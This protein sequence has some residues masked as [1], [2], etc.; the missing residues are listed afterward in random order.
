MHPFGGDGELGVSIRISG[1]GLAVALALA[2]TCAPAAAQYQYGDPFLPGY[3]YAPEDYGPRY[4]APRYY[5]PRYQAPSYQASRYHAPRN[6]AHKD[7]DAD[8]ASTAP[9]GD[10]AKGPLQ[11]YVSIDQQKLYLYSDGVHI[12]DTSVATGVPSLPTPLGVFSIIQKQRYHESN[13]YSNAPMPFMERITW[14]GV[15]L[16]EGENIGHRASHG[17][18]RLPHDFAV[19]LYGVT[20]LGVPVVVANAELKPVEFADPHLFVH[21]DTSPPAPRDVATATP[22]ADMAVPVTPVAD[23]PAKDTPAGDGNKI[24]AAT[25]TVQA[26]PAK[27]DQLGLRVATAP[28]AALPAPTPAATPDVPAKKTPISIFISR[29]AKKIYVRQDFE[30]VFDAPVSIDSP[31][32]PLG[33]HVFTALDFLPDHTK[34][35]WNVVSLPVAPPSA[36]HKA[37]DDRRAEK[38][39]RRK[40]EDDG[41]RGADLPPPQTPAQALARIGIPQNAVDF[42]AQLMVPGSSLVVSDQGLGDETG[43]GTGFIVVTQ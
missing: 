22:A 2:M 28:P 38:H 9:F 4:Y 26:A 32:Q 11:I 29:K 37:D 18:I 14:S 10:I 34:L 39:G 13:I 25:A 5:A 7:K 35:R 41:K 8:R 24:A 36:K 40:D 17:C 19:R 42:I 15:A 12:A 3:G 20:K 31:D 1:S 30:P 27:P 16:H 33:T 23:T 6:T 43:D 21:K